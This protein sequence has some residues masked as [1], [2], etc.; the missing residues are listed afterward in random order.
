MPSM[1]ITTTAPQAQRLVTAFGDRLALGRDAT[2]AEIK[3]WTIAQLR[4]VVRSYER[5][6]AVAT[7][8]D[9]IP[10]PTSFDPT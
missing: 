1:T 6:V 9:A 4:E 5:K 3:A 10:A 7:A 8:V 2:E